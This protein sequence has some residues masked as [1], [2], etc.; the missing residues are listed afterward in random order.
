[1]KRNQSYKITLALAL[2]MVTQLAI[3]SFIG[4]TTSNDRR[5][6]YS[7]K[8]FNR[9]LTKNYSLSAFRAENY[10]FNGLQI[11]NAQRNPSTNNIEVNS[12]MRFQNG[13]TSYVFPY[14]YKV[15][16]SKFKTP[17]ASR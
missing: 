13:N 15:K 1:M 12:I 11:L 9:S 17:S 16:T 8:N 3:G 4:S 10:Q 7:L 2:A 14:K 5:E 6:K